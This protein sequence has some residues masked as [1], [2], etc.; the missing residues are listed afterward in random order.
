VNRTTRQAQLVLLQRTLEPDGLTAAD[1]RPP[2]ATG[3]A[4]ARNTKAE[5]H[6]GNEQ[7]ILCRDCGGSGKKRERT[8]ERACSTCKGR[9]VE[10]VD[11]YTLRRLTTGDQ[12]GEAKPARM[13]RCDGC[14]GEGKGPWWRL[15]DELTNTCRRCWGAKLVLAPRDPIRPFRVAMPRSSVETQSADPLLACME[16]RQEEGSY[17]ELYLALAVLKT[18]QRTLFR[19]DVE[20]FVKAEREEDELMTGELLALEQALGY[21]AILMPT[22]IRVPSWAAQVEQRR[23]EQVLANRKREG[24]AA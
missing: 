21:L 20:V 18:E 3:A 14:G 16:R 8:I 7:T 5:A 12:K 24:V 11:E 4:I 9:C 2:T 1:Y 23:R 22:A 13:V 17:D 10:V 19:L 6:E 15:G